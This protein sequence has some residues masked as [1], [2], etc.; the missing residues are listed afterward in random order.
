MGWR[1]ASATHSIIF[2]TRFRGASCAIPTRRLS[3]VVGV[4]RDP[5][6]GDVGKDEHWHNHQRGQQASGPVH[7]E[8]HVD[9]GHQEQRDDADDGGNLK[10]SDT[11]PLS[12][13]AFAHAMCGASCSHHCGDTHANTS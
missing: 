9:D 11:Y 13:I 5:Q 2:P 3:L 8:E 1:F 7:A 4:P 10:S 12:R 6:G